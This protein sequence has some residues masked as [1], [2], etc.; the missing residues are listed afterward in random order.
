MSRLDDLIALRRQLDMEIERERATEA[1]LRQLRL[2]AIATMTRGSWNTRVFYAACEHY[3]L[4]ANKVLDGAR[5]QSSI[6]AR[7][8]AMWLMHDAKRSYSEIGRQLGMDH[9]SVRNGVLRVA[10]DPELLAGARD[11]NA[12]LTG[13]QE[14]AA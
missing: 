10:A 12:V 6:N 8:V 7:H 9:T 11:I 3:G 5:E 1:R 4:D 14:N 13:D 2:N